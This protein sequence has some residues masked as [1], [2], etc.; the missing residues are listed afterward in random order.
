MSG[1]FINGFNNKL[2]IR[3]KKGC[4]LNRCWFCAASRFSCF[5]L[6]SPPPNPKMG[7]DYPY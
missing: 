1:S 4:T 5:H 6:L 3:T 7:M 2:T